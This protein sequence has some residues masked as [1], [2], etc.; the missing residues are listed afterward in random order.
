[1]TDEI[2]DW[3]RWCAWLRTAEADRNTGALVAAELAL[4][5]VHRIDLRNRAG[6]EWAVCI[7]RRTP[8]ELAAL[9]LQKVGLRTAGEVYGE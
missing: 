5:N 3:E 8:D 9:Y 7:D 6:L 2:R 1:M 4:L